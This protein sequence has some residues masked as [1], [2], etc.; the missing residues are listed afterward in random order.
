MCRPTATTTSA[1]VPRALCGQRRRW[2][3]PNPTATPLPAGAC[4]GAKSRSP[5]GV[6]PPSN[7]LTEGS[8]GPA[9]PVGSYGPTAPPGFFRPL[10]VVCRSWYGEAEFAPKQPTAVRPD[11]LVQRSQEQPF[12]PFRIHL[13]DGTVYEIRHREP[14]KVERS[15]AYVLFSRPGRAARRPYP[16]TLSPC[17]TSPAGSPSVHRRRL[18]PS[19][20]GDPRPQAGGWLAV[21]FK[22]QRHT[23]HP[24]NGLLRTHTTQL[25]ATPVG[26]RSS[27]HA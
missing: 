7:G 21:Y 19:E 24:N 16:T 25:A 20:H 15:K 1:S 27:R 17:C 8:A 11:D 6:G 22:P 23:E 14:V 12:P 10:A 13:T 4:R 5:S 9:G 2:R 3:R 18:L 26:H